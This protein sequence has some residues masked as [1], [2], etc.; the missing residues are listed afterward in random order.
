MT[1]GDG[2]TLTSLRQ[3]AVIRY[4]Y[5]LT[6]EERLFEP[7]WLAPRITFRNVINSLSRAKSYSASC[8]RRLFITVHVYLGAEPTSPSAHFS[9]RHSVSEEKQERKDPFRNLEAVNR[10]SNLIVGSQSVGFEKSL[11]AGQRKSLP[12]NRVLSF[13]KSCA[14]PIDHA[15]RN[16]FCCVS[17]RRAC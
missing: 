6:K 7:D 16:Q 12:N 14:F 13:Q 11:P 8:V 3:N 1:S 17:C 15:G 10:S 9:E 2:P 5:P 4:A